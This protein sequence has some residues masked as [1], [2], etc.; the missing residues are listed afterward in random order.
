MHGSGVVARIFDE[1]HLSFVPRESSI[2]LG[3]GLTSGLTPVA[4]QHERLVPAV[5]TMRVRIAAGLEVIDDRPGRGRRE[6]AEKDGGEHHAHA[7]HATSIQAAE[8]GK[9]GRGRVALSELIPHLPEHLQ[10]PASSPRRRQYPTT[11]VQ[12]LDKVIPA[13]VMVRP[14]SLYLRSV[15]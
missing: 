4:R 13:Q 8:S 3:C 14:F 10:I 2:V 12:S 1:D 7:D 6:S 5:G 11:L 9:T 15:K